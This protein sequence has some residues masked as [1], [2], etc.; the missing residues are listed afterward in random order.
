M[1]TCEAWPSETPNSRASRGSSAS[2]RRIDTPLANAASASAVIANTGT[3]GFGWRARVFSDIRHC[4]GPALG[5]WAGGTKALANCGAAKVAAK[6][7]RVLVFFENCLKILIK[8]PTDL[9][10]LN[11]YQNK[12]PQ[13]LLAKSAGLSHHADFVQALK[14]CVRRGQALVAWLGRFFSSA[15]AAPEV[16]ASCVRVTTGRCSTP[17]DSFMLRKILYA[18]LMLLGCALSGCSAVPVFAV[19]GMQAGATCMNCGASS[20][21]VQALTQAPMCNGMCS[22]CSR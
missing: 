14:R 22:I 20:Y 4:A 21:R 12:L 15:S 6:L 11:Q 3:G 7:G 17:R 19:P 16:G 2:A 10:Q 1:T 18:G 9:D 13:F 8:I 5:L